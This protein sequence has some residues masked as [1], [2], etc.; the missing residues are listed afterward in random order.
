[1]FIIMTE[2]KGWIPTWNVMT[3]LNIVFHL[4]LE[5]EES[6]SSHKLYKKCRSDT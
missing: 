5:A 1:M 6:V 2:A 4:A 3:S